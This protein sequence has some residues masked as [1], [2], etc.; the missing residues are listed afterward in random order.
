MYA[1]LKIKKEA[2]N[3]NA[4]AKGN[5]MMFNTFVKLKYSLCRISL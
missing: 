1:K 3:S 5:C 2:A 4:S